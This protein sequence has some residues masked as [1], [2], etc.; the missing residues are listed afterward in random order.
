MLKKSFIVKQEKATGQISGK[1]LRLHTYKSDILWCDCDSLIN[2]ICEWDSLIIFYISCANAFGVFGASAV[3]DE[4]TFGRMEKE[5]DV[6]KI[7]QRG[8]CNW[9]NSKG[10]HT[11]SNLRALRVSH[12]DSSYSVHCTL[13]P[14]LDSFLNH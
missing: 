14:I 3:S 8:V 2:Y 6:P 4:V 9:K 10:V 13:K 1:I 5:K 7:R 12:R 11:P